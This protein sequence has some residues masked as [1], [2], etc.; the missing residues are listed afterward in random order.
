MTCP[1]WKRAGVFVLALSILIGL[2][3]SF[4]ASSQPPTPFAEPPPDATYELPVSDGNNRLNLFVS[5]WRFNA[6]ASC[7][8]RLIAPEGRLITNWL[9]PNAVAPRTTV[10]SKLVS[11]CTGRPVYISSIEGIDAQSGLAYWFESDEDTPSTTK[12]LHAVRINSLHTDNADLTIFSVP[13][14]NQPPAK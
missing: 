2:L 13:M 6:D 3:R 5:I 10:A 4:V 9:K 12:V 7:N 1:A 8:V 14:P 11:A